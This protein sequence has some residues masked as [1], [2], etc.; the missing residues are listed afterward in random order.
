MKMPLPVML[1]TSVALKDVLPY[2]YWPGVAIYTH[3]SARVPFWLLCGY[4]IFNE[5]EIQP[6]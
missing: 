2:I 6:T 1:A 3:I 4:S 5:Q